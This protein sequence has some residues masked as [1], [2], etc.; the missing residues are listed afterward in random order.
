MEWLVVEKALNSKNNQ[1]VFKVKAEAKLIFIIW[2]KS[3]REIEAGNIL[4]PV[5]DGYIANHDKGHFV[6]IIK[7][8]PFCSSEWSELITPPHPLLNISKTLE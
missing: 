1:Q 2:V 6:S 5:I 7:V 4:T 8:R 3:N